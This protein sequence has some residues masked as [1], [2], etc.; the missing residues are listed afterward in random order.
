MRSFIT[1]GEYNQTTLP[2]T[3]LAQHGHRRR[4]MRPLAERVAT[5]TQ[6]RVWKRD[7]KEATF[8]ALSQQERWETES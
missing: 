1:K 4:L 2:E 5:G 3:A 8:L 6:L 7:A